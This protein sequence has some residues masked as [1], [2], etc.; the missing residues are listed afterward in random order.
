MKY[1]DEIL[2]TILTNNKLFCVNAYFISINGLLHGYIPGRKHFKANVSSTFSFF[3]NVQT[4]F[5]D[6]NK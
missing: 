6:F 4:A 3:S 2:H 1:N 5:F